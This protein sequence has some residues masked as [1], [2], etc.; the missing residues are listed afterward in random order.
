M[1]EGTLHHA[2]PHDA[3]LDDE[4][5]AGKRVSQGCMN[6]YEGSLHL[7]NSGSNHPM[8]TIGVLSPL[9]LTWHLLKWTSLQE[10]VLPG[11]PFLNKTDEFSEK[12]QT[13]PSFWQTL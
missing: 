4:M 6:M 11:K 1:D 8:P 7:L 13:P 9:F 2:H 12:F 3:G 10:S 5:I